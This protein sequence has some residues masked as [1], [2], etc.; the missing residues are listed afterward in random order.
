[1]VV[2]C[3]FEELELADELG[4]QPLA[5]RHLRF[6]Q[7]LA[8]TTALRLREIRKR[9]LVDLQPF[10]FSEQLRASDGC[11][12]VAGSRDVDQLASLVVAKDQRVER[13]G[14][15]RLRLRSRIPDRG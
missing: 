10:E 9:A 7:P 5:F 8:P 11:E 1:M 2:A 6:R 15:A 13:F 3:P 4:L 14:S 12:R